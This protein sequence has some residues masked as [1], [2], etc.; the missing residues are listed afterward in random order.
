MTRDAAQQKPATSGSISLN[1]KDAFDL[2]A[3]S[4]MGAGAS[5]PRPGDSSPS[6]DRGC[7]WWWPI[8]S[9]GPGV[10]NDLGRLWRHSVAVS[11][12]ARWLARDAGDPDPTAVARAGILCRL[13]CWAVA[14]VDP[15]GGCAGGRRAPALA[16][17]REIADLGAEL[18]DLGRRLAERWGCDPLVIDAVWLHAEHGR[19]L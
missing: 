6:N 15:T 17:T 3:R 8:R 12:A 18:D 13:G 10:G 2:R 11:V 4:G 9:G 19:A 16:A 7:A 1:G 5:R 14:A